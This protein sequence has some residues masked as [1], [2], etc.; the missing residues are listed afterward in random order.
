MP[1]TDLIE[2]ELGSQYPRPSA[3]ATARARAAVM[4]G[5]GGVSRSARRTN[6]RRRRRPVLVVAAAVAALAGAGIAIAA[7]LGAFNGFGATQHP[8]TRAD[9]PNSRTLARIKTLCTDGQYVA[10]YNPYCHLDL[11]GARLLT[12]AA[13][14]FQIGVTSRKVWAIAASD[15][16]VCMVGGF[17]ECTPQ[18]S[19]SVPITF[20]GGNAGPAQT[21]FAAG[22]AID[23]VTS[24]SFVLEPSDG[25]TVTV[26]VKNNIWV[27]EQPNSDATGTKCIV[28]HFANGSTVVPAYLGK[29]SCPS[30]SGR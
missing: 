23:G 25:A 1:D 15:G 21:F 16:E 28:A 19:K 27:Y 3:A 17:W 7:G 11:S 13:P 24:V 4:E 9:V 18:L 10:P 5:V 6:A 20:G 8:P 2:R 14:R 12:S 26:P 29:N 30:R 22:L